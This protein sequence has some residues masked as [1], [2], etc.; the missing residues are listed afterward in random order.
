MN[1]IAPYRVSRMICV[2]MSTDGILGTFYIKKDPQVV[3]NFSDHLSQFSTIKNIRKIYQS[4]SQCTSC[5][6]HSSE[7]TKIRE[8]IN[9]L[10]NPK[11]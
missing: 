7:N 8:Y 1:F 9:K 10:E 11:L 2:E 5:R 4:E 3:P 6:N